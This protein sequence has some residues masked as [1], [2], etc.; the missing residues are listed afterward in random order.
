MFMRSIGT[1]NGTVA[2]LFKS[3]SHDPSDSDE[4]SDDS[5]LEVKLPS[6]RPFSREL[7]DGAIGEECVEELVEHMNVLGR[8]A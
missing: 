5:T 1:G 7:F 4:E 6:D 8:H 3:A 2:H